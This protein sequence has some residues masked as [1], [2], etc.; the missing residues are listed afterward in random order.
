MKIQLDPSD[1]HLIVPAI[2]VPSRNPQR[3]VNHIV[4]SREAKYLLL[5]YN[6]YQRIGMHQGLV[7]S[8]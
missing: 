5:L 6:R 3:V 8:Q 1:E 2:A 4:V 7:I